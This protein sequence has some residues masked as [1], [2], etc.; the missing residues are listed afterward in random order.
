MVSQHKC[1]EVISLLKL[2]KSL[3]YF[4]LVWGLEGSAGDIREVGLGM[5]KYCLLT[6]EFENCFSSYTPQESHLKEALDKGPQTMKIH[7]SLARQ[8]TVFDCNSL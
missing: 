8:R 7:K 5:E 2:A 4:G 6:P 1:E 3:H